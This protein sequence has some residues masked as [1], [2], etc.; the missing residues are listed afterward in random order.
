MRYAL[1]IAMFLGFSTIARAQ[2]TYDWTL[3][4]ADVTGTGTFE[5]GTWTTAGG[6]VLYPIN[7]LSGRLNGL[8]LSLTPGYIITNPNSPTAEMNGNAF[9]AQALPVAPSWPLYFQSGAQKFELWQSDFFQPGVTGQVLYGLPNGSASVTFAVKPA[10]QPL[11]SRKNPIA[12]IG[13]IRVSLPAGV[14]VP[15]SAFRGN[16]NMAIGIDVGAAVGGI[17]AL[18]EWNHHRQHRE[19]VPAGRL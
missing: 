7:N 12:P 5:V 18:Y 9:Y 15:V 19:A 17:S 3:A 2:S 10:A 14:N 1:A 11:L 4:G 8:P 13:P 16:R 6:P